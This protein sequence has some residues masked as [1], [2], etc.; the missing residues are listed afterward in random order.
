MPWIEV[1]VHHYTVNNEAA[2]PDLVFREYHL[3]QM[4]MSILSH[5]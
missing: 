5:G 3:R 1:V 2:A 4:N